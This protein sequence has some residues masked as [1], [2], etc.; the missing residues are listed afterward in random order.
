METKAYQRVTQIGFGIAYLL[1]ICNEIVGKIIRH[2]FVDGVFF[3]IVSILA[4][5]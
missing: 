1:V 2:K 5:G 4:F 3:V